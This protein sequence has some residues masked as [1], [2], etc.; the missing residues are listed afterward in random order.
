MKKGVVQKPSIK[1][2]IKAGRTNPVIFQ[3]R[4]FQRG[5]SGLKQL[6]HIMLLIFAAQSLMV[7]AAP[8][9][10]DHE[11]NHQGDHRMDQAVEQIRPV[12]EM[13]DHS[14]HSMP[15]HGAYTKIN[16]KADT[17]TD[18]KSKVSNKSDN[19]CD[20][21]SCQMISCNSPAIASSI[22]TFSHSAHT[23][24]IADPGHYRPLSP[25]TPSLLR[26]PISA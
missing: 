20:S 9:P 2:L 8:C 25:S 22:A 24:V 19:C 21:G 17:N 7:T 15:H 14:S 13:H 26:P 3:S 23:T 18:I 11:L 5:G 12:A 1:P 10:M 6:I 16:A 4:H